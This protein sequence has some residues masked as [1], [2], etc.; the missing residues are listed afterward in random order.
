M[1]TAKRAANRKNVGVA[2]VPSS[3]DDVDVRGSHYSRPAACDPVRGLLLARRVVRPR[4]QA[5]PRI[6][7]RNGGADGVLL[8]FSRRQVLSMCVAAMPR[9]LNKARVPCARHSPAD[10]GP[11]TETLAGSSGAYR[12]LAAGSEP[13][14]AICGSEGDP[15]SKCQAGAVGAGGADGFAFLVV[16]ALGFLIVSC[17]CK[18]CSRPGHPAHGHYAAAIEVPGA[19]QPPLAQAAPMYAPQYAQQFAQGGFQQ[20]PQGG[21]QQPC[22]LPFGYAQAQAYPAYTQTYPAQGFSAGT[23]AASAGAGFLGG[24]LVDRACC[25]SGGGGRHHHGGGGGD[26]GGGGGGDDGFAADN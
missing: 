11:V 18:Q 7:L 19:Y 9:P 16:A 25:G 1:F 4:L 10:P 5:R 23:V 17:F 2:S 8:P 13:S 22:A 20:Y 14:C 6:L 12:C 21:F 15:R 24:T 26:F 3:E